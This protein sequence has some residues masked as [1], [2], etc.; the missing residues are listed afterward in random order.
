MCISSFQDFRH[1]YTHTHTEK[2]IY[3]QYTYDMVGAL[4]M[5]AYVVTG[6][7]KREKM[8]ETGVEPAIS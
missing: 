3:I 1:T 6:Y 7:R 2:T 4:A 5:I 8:T